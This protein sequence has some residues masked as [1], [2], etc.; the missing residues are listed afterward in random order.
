MFVKKKRR[1][2]GSFQFISAA[3]IQGVHENCG[4]SEF[5]TSR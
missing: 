2:P 3:T 1:I 5:M 4:A